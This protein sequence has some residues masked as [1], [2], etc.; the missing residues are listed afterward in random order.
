MDLYGISQRNTDIVGE[1][2]RVSEN[3]DGDVG[4]CERSA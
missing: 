1:T 3:Q 2:R 4:E